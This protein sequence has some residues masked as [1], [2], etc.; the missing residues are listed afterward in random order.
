VTNAT[1]LIRTLVQAGFL[2]KHSFVDVIISK[3]DLVAAEISSEIEL[4]LATLREQL[5]RRFGNKIARLAFREV[6]ARGSEV[7]PFGFGLDERFAAWANEAPVRSFASS[8]LPAV[9]PTREMARYAGH[10]EGERPDE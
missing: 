4:Y 10:A 3:W 8:A 5:E 6:A 2:G 1:T 7:V 9:E